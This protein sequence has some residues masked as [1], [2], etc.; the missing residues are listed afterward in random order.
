MT[1]PMITLDMLILVAGWLLAQFL[2]NGFEA[3]VPLAKRVS[4]LLVI[5]VIFLVIDLFVGRWLFYALLLLM[6]VGIGILHGYWF[7][8]R[9]GIHWRTAEPRE[10][11]LRLIGEGGDE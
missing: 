9:H 5:F 2:F 7:H 6:T 3:H 10:K 8:R 1:M 11:Y 4:K